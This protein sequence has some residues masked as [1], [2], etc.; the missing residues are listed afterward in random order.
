M[1]LLFFCTMSIGLKADPCGVLDSLAE[2]QLIIDC[3]GSLVVKAEESSHYVFGTASVGDI[4]EF[5]QESAPISHFIPTHLTPGTDFEF[6]IKEKCADKTDPSKHY[7]FPVYGVLNVAGEGAGAGTYSFNG[8]GKTPSD[9]ATQTSS[10]PTA[11]PKGVTP[12]VTASVIKPTCPGESNG[13]VTLSLGNV[14]LSKNC[15][16]GIEVSLVTP[17]SS[18]APAKS[19][20]F[21][22]NQLVLL[23]G[24]GTYELTFAVNAAP[25]D[26]VCPLNAPA[27]ITVVI[28][29]A[30][31]KSA[32]IACIDRVNM[33]SSVDPTDCSVTIELSDIMLGVGDPCTANDSAEYINVRD[34]RT[35]ELIGTGLMG[36]PG[37][38]APN[39]QTGSGVAV[40]LFP[41]H[42]TFGEEVIVE[43]H[44]AMSG[45]Y[46]WGTVLIEDKAAPVITCNNPGR[47]E[48][49]CIEYD[50]DDMAESLK[51]AI[52]DCSD[53]DVTIVRRKD[54]EA[55][56]GS[57]MSRV[58][59]IY[60]AEDEWG[61][62]S[63]QCTD[64]VDIVRIV[65]PDS[66]ELTFIEEIELIWPEDRGKGNN[67]FSCDGFTD[68]DGDGIPDPTFDG[69]GMPILVLAQGGGKF[70]TFPLPALTFDHYSSDLQ[71]R[72]AKAMINCKIGASYQDI[73]LGTYDCVTKYMRR[74][75]IGEWSCEGEKEVVYQQT[76]EIVD[77]L[78]PV[79]LEAIP[80]AEVSVNS[81]SCTKFKP[82]KMPKAVDNCTSVHYQAVAY[83]SEWNVI[84]P[85]IYDG[86]EVE[87]K[88]GVNYVVYD[89][90]DDCHNVTKD[91]SIVTV[92]D[93][94]A[95]VTVCKEF[96]VVGIS[97]DGTVRVPATAFDNGSYDDCALESTCVVRMDDQ[98]TFDA[99][100]T[101]GDGWVNMTD[102]YAAPLACTRADWYGEFAVERG[103]DKVLQLHRGDL[104]QPNIWF[105]CDDDASENED[106]VMVIFRATDVSGNSNECM[107]FV[108]IQD[109]TK[110]SISCPA[111]VTVDC[112]LPLP[113]LDETTLG[114]Y[115]LQDEDPLSALFG[116]I[117]AEHFQEPFGVHPS[118]VVSDNEDELFDGV[119]YDNC[120][121]INIYVR[122]DINT[123]QCNTGE[124][125]RSFYAEDNSGNRSN[126]CV[127]TITIESEVDFD[128]KNIKWPEDAELT[129]CMSE[130]DITATMFGVPEAADDACMLFGTSYED[131]VFR[132]NN[133]DNPDADAC[134][135][136][137][138]TW[139]VIDWCNK[140]D[141]N[142]NSYV[143]P[144]KQVIKVNDPDAPVIVCDDIDPVVT[145]DCE[146]ATVELFAT[147]TDECTPTD[148]LF[149]Q[150]KVDI[151]N[152]GDYDYKFEDLA[153][154][155]VTT[156]DGVVLTKSFPIGQHRVFWVVEDRCGNL[157][158]CES[159]F[160]VEL[161]KPATPFAVDVS[162]VLMSSGM[163]AIWASDL[164]NK[165]AGPCNQDAAVLISRIN[166]TFDQAA[167]S[168]TFTCQ[169][170]VDGPDVD[171][172][173]WAYVPGVPNSEDYATVTVTLQDNQGAC[174]GFQGGSTEGTGQN[175]FITGRINTESS[176]QVP[177]VEVGLLGGN[178]GASALDATT[179]NTRG[180]YAFPAMPMGGAYVIDPV[181][182]TDYLNGV[183]TLDL[184]MIQR[185]VLG[186]SDLESEYKIIAADVNNDNNVSAIDLVDLRSVILGVSDKFTNN[187]SWRFIDA[188]YTFADKQNPLAENFSESYTIAGLDT[189]MNIDFVGVKVGDVNGSV[190]AASILAQSRSRFDMIVADQSFSA[191]DIV[192]VPVRVKSGI[193]MIGVQFTVEFDA[194]TLQFAGVDANGLNVLPQ[195]I[196][197]NRSADGIV[198]MSWNDVEAVDLGADEAIVTMN[199]KAY[200]AG[201]IAQSFFINSKVAQAEVYNANLET[202]DINLTYS[203]ESGVLASGFELMQNTPNP[204][205]DQTVISF[206]LPAKADATLS[207]FDVTG[208]VL[209]VIKGS[210]D[211]GLNTIE[212][213][214]SDLSSTGVLYY[215]LET[216]G[217]T[218]TKRMVVLK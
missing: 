121:P 160:S 198:T 75:T 207:V 210:F 52:D 216:D 110:P 180:E 64:T 171:I 82:I 141:H 153:D 55:C 217:F 201:S 194:A 170:F 130:E 15:G 78:A 112:E 73:K 23:G 113:S 218:D 42:F 11:K 183:T 58:E 85:D 49:L 111:D 94:S 61:R 185:Y 136:L 138:R 108:D 169:D 168:I 69:A 176:V 68:V 125:T 65:E 193:D 172:K 174:D 133:R 116:K 187:D 127:Q 202:M 196:A 204:F 51:S 188:N 37:S 152:D 81:Y 70:D 114:T 77:T 118:H 90:Y 95:P 38:Y 131:Q 97:V 147:A 80:D 91:T 215:T 135:K 126:V 191:G 24:A 157:S 67:P 142:S 148:E 117:A 159:V 177:D 43:V 26:C 104:C 7:Y 134:F 209:K 19:M 197:T 72:R 165:S 119:Y 99:L 33:S 21:E 115:I 154:D 123:N 62:A 124:I 143:V 175:A 181:S 205:A 54:I 22:N 5:Y 120:K 144:H 192:Q 71:E 74:W 208:K 17:P 203:K 128:Y 212:L 32:S 39:A 93:K 164:D 56:E 41:G 53:F 35:N 146:G 173:F 92:V 45:N 47:T 28:P 83:D 206:L 101:D 184:V 86:D 34:P 151:D 12:K 161:N 63:D 31:D 1:P 79:L 109:K 100:D 179:T 96:L 27:S 13:Q 9:R 89:I 140:D 36:A 122:V 163:V 186:I 29:E 30:S 158:T 84:G 102:L 46:C 4:A 18:L 213:N 190:D 48:I 59:L 57:V 103:K 14:D 107:V 167:S 44:D 50:G 195:N 182:S 66:S 129:T 2:I 3:D 6:Y 25:Q 76:I 106:D 149:W 137:I 98:E 211:G 214:K 105:C 88:L 40:R 8:V 87:F 199:F 145:T 166:E 178:Q 139:N 20:S 10:S 162:T 189:D 132:F 60:F 156:N 155:I 150:V 200:A 16:A